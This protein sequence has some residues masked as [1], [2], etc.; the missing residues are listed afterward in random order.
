MLEKLSNLRRQ[1]IIFN[2]KPFL[3]G[4]KTGLDVGCNSGTLSKEIS[5]NLNIEMTGI[6]IINPEKKEIN[7]KLFNGKKIPFKSNS[8]DSVF[9]FDVL[10][11]IDSRTQMQE[12]L[13]ECF[14]VTKKTVIIK[15]HYYSNVF[16]K[17]FIKLMD[18]I[19]NFL[20]KVPTP[21]NFIKKNEWDS[22]NSIQKKYWTFIGTPNIIIKFDKNNAIN[23]I[24]T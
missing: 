16:Q 15:D 20:P 9:L 2:L 24:K 12:L 1:D 6:D 17:Q 10:H 23:L 21:L 18:V 19:T 5:N 11:H 14:R 22:M 4:E 13:T 8:F 3:N 7:F